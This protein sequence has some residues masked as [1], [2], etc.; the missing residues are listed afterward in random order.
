MENQPMKR[1]LED[2]LSDVPA[3]ELEKPL[4]VD[5]GQEK[6]EPEDVALIRKIQDGMKN[7][8]NVNGSATQ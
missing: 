2:H 8:K 7:R 3:D 5:M 6:L 4:S 1:K